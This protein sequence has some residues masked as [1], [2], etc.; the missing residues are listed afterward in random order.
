[1]KPVRITRRRTHGY[2]MQAESRRVN[3]LDCIAVTRPGKWGNPYDIA[4][5]GR[6]LA[7]AVFRNTALGIW[8]PD[9]LAGRP[10]RVFDAIYAAHKRWLRRVGGHPLEAIRKEL[11]GHNLSCYCDQSVACHADIYLEILSRR[12]T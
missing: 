6:S 5:Y 10:K 2:N 9:L 11:H 7:L 8:D 3:G 4:I 1:M 12:D